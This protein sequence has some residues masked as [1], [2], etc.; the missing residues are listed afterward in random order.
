MSGDIVAAGTGTFAAAGDVTLSGGVATGALGSFVDG[1]ESSGLSG[2]LTVT[3]ES[4][5]ITSIGNYGITV[6]S[7]DLTLT[8][9]TGGITAGAY[10]E[11]YNGSLTLTAESG[12]IAASGYIYGREDV[13]L[14][15]SGGITSGGYIRSVD[16][17]SLIHI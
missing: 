11:S 14:N 16:G 12:D 7:G 17:L 2:D 10:I 1:L 13:M 3:S 6:Y 4:G 5:D 9:E 15:A 8:A